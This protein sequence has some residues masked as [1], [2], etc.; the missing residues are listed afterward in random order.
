LKPAI[1]IVD[2]LE[3]WWERNKDK[4]RHIHQLV[5]NLYNAEQLQSW[6]PVYEAADRVCGQT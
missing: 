2:G 4:Y 6:Y 3:Y 5:I 1:F